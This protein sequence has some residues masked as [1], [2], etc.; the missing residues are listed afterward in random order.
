M[1]S[2]EDFRT[3]AG[4]MPSKNGLPYEITTSMA[5]AYMRDKLNGVLDRAGLGRMDMKLSSMEASKIFLPFIMILPMSAA[6]NKKDSNNSMPAFFNQKQE[7]RTVPL[8]DPI[9]NLL[10]G[11]VYTKDDT[12]AFFSDD[13][14]RRTRVSR[15]TASKLKDLSIPR[16]I[17]ASKDKKG[18]SIICVLIDPMK[19][20]HDML[21]MDADTR[22]FT[23]DVYDS[24]KK[25]T[26]EYVYFISRKLV[27]SKNNKNRK[28]IEEMLNDKI[29]FGGRNNG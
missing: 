28:S 18:G 16:V 22:Q 19:V 6:K 9:F 26:C 20:F 25:S 10:K 15:E 24:K 4:V 29:R 14:R 21:T 5:E 23:T 27:D 3:R 12:H 7:D 2:V 17:S 13:W 1:A 11:Y 8:Q